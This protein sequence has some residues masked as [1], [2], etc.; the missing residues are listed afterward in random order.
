MIGKIHNN[1]PIINIMKIARLKK[2]KYQVC[3]GSLMKLV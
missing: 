3:T 1:F 2:G